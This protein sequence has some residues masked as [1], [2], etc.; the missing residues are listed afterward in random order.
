MVSRDRLFGVPDA[1][2]LHF[3]LA[4]AYE[5]EIE[6]WIEDG[7][8]APGVIEEWTVHPPEYHLPSAE[9]IAEDIIE[10]AADDTTEGYYDATAHIWKEA[11]VLAAA[12]A[13]RQVIASH[14]TYRMADKKVAEH[15]ITWDDE[16]EPLVDGQPMYVKSV[17][18]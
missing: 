10:N 5:S 2:N 12:E 18:G 7:G 6:P 15:Q 8:R 17:T 14:I 4:S 16:G 13:L 11:D 9:R 3:D 1:E